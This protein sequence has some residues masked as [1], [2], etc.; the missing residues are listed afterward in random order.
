V[1][2]AYA[3]LL[4]ALASVSP[5]PVAAHSGPPFVV[6]ADQTAGPYTISVWADPDLGG[7]QI[8]VQVA[9]PAGAQPAVSVAARPLDGHLAEVVVP[10]ERGGPNKS[11]GADTWV[12]TLPF[13]AEGTWALT[14][15]LAGAEGEGRLTAPVD[16]RPDGPSPGEA[17]L[18]VMPFAL[19]AAAWLFGR[20]RH[21]DRGA[22]PA[23]DSPD[24]DPADDRV[25]TQV[26][27]GR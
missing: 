23:P 22:A 3:A 20:W 11:V 27:T 19:L 13:D 14:V 21:R 4:L 5:L 12:A 2:G 8:L 6:V 25:D 17:W 1:S 9:A 26:P 18:Y 15:Q 10:A 7:G 16:V 24:A